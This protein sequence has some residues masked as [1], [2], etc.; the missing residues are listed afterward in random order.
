M[1]LRR[2]AH[3]DR[4]DGACVIESKTWAPTGH[5]AGTFSGAVGRLEFGTRNHGAYSLRVPHGAAHH[6]VL[7]PGHT[8]SR[9]AS[10]GRWRDQH[11]K[12]W[13]VAEMVKLVGDFKRSGSRT[14][15][16]GVMTPQALDS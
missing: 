3:R 1:P 5:V 16:L 9:C 13:D 6:C 11:N 7:R 14:K 8:A 15:R 2:R 4:L 12:L 10:D